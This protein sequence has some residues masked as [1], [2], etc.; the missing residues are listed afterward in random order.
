MHTPLEQLQQDNYQ[1]K[2]TFILVCLVGERVAI[3]KKKPADED[4][5]VRYTTHYYISDNL[6]QTF[7]AVCKALSHLLLNLD[8]TFDAYHIFSDGANH[9]KAKFM[10]GWMAAANRDITWDCFPAGHGKG[11]WDSEGYQLKKFA[12]DIARSAKQYEMQGEIVDARSL[13]EVASKRM[14]L[15]AST[16]VVCSRVF[17][18]LPDLVDISPRYGS[19]TLPGIGATSSPSALS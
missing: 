9:F 2:K 1:K 10:L 19:M 5:M 13:Y 17:N 12:L 3:E 11:P 15:A 16:H 6:T 4:W 18:F 7:P 14:K 8:D